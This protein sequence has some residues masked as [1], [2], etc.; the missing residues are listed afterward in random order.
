MALI[1]L[2]GCAESAVGDG[3]RVASE[4]TAAKDSVTD[5]SAAEPPASSDSEDGEP[6]SDD[7]ENYWSWRE[8]LKSQPDGK[9]VTT[10]ADNTFDCDYLKYG[11]LGYDFDE[12]HLSV[13]APIGW[14]TFRFYPYCD[15]DAAPFENGL[16]GMPIYDGELPVK[17]RDMP[18]FED[19]SYFFANEPMEKSTFFLAFSPWPYPQDFID[20]R[21]G[22]IDKF[23]HETYTDKKGRT[24]QVYYL[25]GLPK[26]ICYDDFFSICIWLNLKSEEQIPTIVNMINSIKV[27][28]S[29]EAEQ[30]LSVAQRQ[31]FTVIPPE[32]YEGELYG[33]LKVESYNP[34][35]E[36][37][38]VWKQEEAPYDVEEYKDIIRGYGSYWADFY[39]DLLTR[40]EG[41]EVSVFADNTLE[42]DY[43]GYQEIGYRFG[44]LYRSVMAPEG[45]QGFRFYRDYYYLKN[46]FTGI[47][48]YDGDIPVKIMDGDLTT[49]RA[50]G[51]MEKSTFY[52][53]EFA[54]TETMD[55]IREYEAKFDHETYTDKNGRTMQVYFLDGLP[56]YARYDD[57][58]N[59]CIWFNLKS[60]EQ[61][62]IVVNM[63]NSVDVSLSSEAEDALELAQSFGY[64]VVPPEE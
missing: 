51:P 27:S 10:L 62:P 37:G 3:G 54:W 5:T 49:Y 18:P 19:Y 23:D 25:N 16:S 42:C 53:A 64:T 9:E 59:L 6:G 55:V 56:K 28:M 12:L 58:Y 35:D 29:H 48:I 45:W 21:N 17:L 13:M 22:L 4:L 24:M 15:C 60:E 38:G 7:T 63:I 39:N 31:G 36:L 44:P 46:E 34:S 61:I 40:P 47:P 57:F 33:Y 52:L 32:D 11:E 20:D 41:G 50:A 14:H 1:M 2:C 43:S 26:Y 30:I 8:D